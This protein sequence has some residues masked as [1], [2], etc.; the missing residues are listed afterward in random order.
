M[1]QEPNPDRKGR[2]WES[3]GSEDHEMLSTRREAHDGTREHVE[4]KNTFLAERRKK[5]R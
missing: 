4:N 1:K 5:D 3:L 2:C